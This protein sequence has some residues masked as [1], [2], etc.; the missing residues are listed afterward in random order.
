MNG[1]A[2]FSLD[3]SVSQR[4]V[5]EQ[6]A[7]QPF[8]M[9]VEELDQFLQENLKAAY[10]QASDMELEEI[11]I[12]CEL[13]SVVGSCPG[14]EIDAESCWHSQWGF[15]IQ[16]WRFGNHGHWIRFLNSCRLV[17]CGSLD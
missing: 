4:K 13:S 14:R 5:K 7:T 8:E 1:T 17:S 16:R 6:E 11:R 15:F 12:P 9:E 3:G 10:P 2:I